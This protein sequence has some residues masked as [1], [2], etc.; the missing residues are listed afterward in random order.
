MKPRAPI[1]LPEPPIRWLGIGLMVLAVALPFA[2]LTLRAS[3]WQ[4][5]ARPENEKAPAL[6]PAMV[7]LPGGTFQMGS[8]PDETDRDT[9]ETLHE[10][11]LD[12]FLVSR[13]EVTQGQYFAVMG[14]RPVAEREGDLFDRFC[15][16]AGLGDDLPVVCIDWFEAIGYCNALSLREGLDPVYTIEGERVTRN[17]GAEGYR[18]LTEAEWEY[19]A[20]A[21]TQDVWVGTR[22][23]AEV[24]EFANVADAAGKAKNPNWTTFECNDTFPALAPVGA[25]RPNRWLLHGLGGNA[26]EWV[27]DTYKTSFPEERENPVADDPNASNRLF[28]GGS[29]GSIPRY[30]RVANRDGVAPSWRN[31]FVGFRVARSLPSSL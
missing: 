24:C 6:R 20:R 9:D 25:R 28:R 23:A 17:Q 30:A 8:P 10:V 16:E 11:M 2:A 19:A 7:R 22:V 26:A 4:A 27:W 3:R 5:P 31:D 13:T 15:K 18:L 12:A 14:E 29:W 1:L 21:G